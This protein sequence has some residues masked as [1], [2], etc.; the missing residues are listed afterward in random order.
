MESEVRFVLENE[1]RFVLES[2]VRFVLQS[3]V[4]FVLESEVRFVLKSEVM[5]AK[6][7]E[8][9]GDKIGLISCKWSS[10]NAPGTEKPLPHS[11]WENSIFPFSAFLSLG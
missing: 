6:N 4:R 5:R 11:G 3:E 8:N 1:V 9:F 2:E 10:L 7:L